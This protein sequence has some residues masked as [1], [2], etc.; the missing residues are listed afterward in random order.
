[1]THAT[2]SLLPHLLNAQIM[3]QNAGFPVFT[4]MPEVRERLKFTEDQR[5]KIVEI[6][7]D[8]NRQA[9]PRSALP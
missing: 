1:M 6:Q 8:L 7:E 4:F 5:A 2:Y 3:I 9:G